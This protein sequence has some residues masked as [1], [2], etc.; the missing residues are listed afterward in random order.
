MN[1]TRLFFLASL[2]LCLTAAA[3]GCSLFSDSSSRD[4]QSGSGSDAVSLL[5]RGEIR[6]TGTFRCFLPP[7]TPD[8]VRILLLRTGSRMELTPSFRTADPQTFSA[9][10]R[11]GY[12]DAAYDGTI[13]EA[14]AA[15]RQLK[16]IPLPVGGMLL[17][18]PEDPVWEE[19]LQDAIPLD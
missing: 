14:E 12:A 9:M 18:R 19:E 16:G 1:E 5:R 17:I 7:D 6:R 13:T 11:A 8:A 3:S 2:L 10:L 4:G 15:R